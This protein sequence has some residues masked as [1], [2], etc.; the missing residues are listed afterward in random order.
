MED[1]KDIEKTENDKKLNEYKPKKKKINIIMI[2]IELGSIFILL[3]ILF[4]NSV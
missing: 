3:S 2:I 1:I 4:P